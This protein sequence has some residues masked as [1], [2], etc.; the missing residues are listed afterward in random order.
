MSQ[1]NNYLVE[2]A[3]FKVILPPDSYAASANTGAWVDARGFK[4]VTFYFMLGDTIANPVAVKLQQAED[5]SGTNA[6]DVPGKTGA[7]TAT[8]DDTGGAISLCVC[9]LSED[10]P[11]VTAVVTPDTAAAEMS[12]VAILSRASSEPVANSDLTFNVV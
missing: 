11:F 5:A 9:E 3:D 12:V 2:Q 7:Y 10:N 8:D 6:S 1:L 4:F